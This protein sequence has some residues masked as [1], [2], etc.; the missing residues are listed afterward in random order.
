MSKLLVIRHAQASFMAEDYDNLSDFGH[1]QS[2]ALGKYLVERGV[3][4][5]HSVIG[6]LKRHHQTAHHVKEAFLKNGQSW[7]D[8]LH[9]GF[10]EHKAP[11]ITRYFLEKWNKKSNPQPITDEK[12]HKKKYFKAFEQIF[13][14]WIKDELDLSNTEFDKWLVFKNRVLHGLKEVMEQYDNGS[15]TAIFTSGGPVGVIT[16]EALGLVDEKTVEL[17][18]QVQNTSVT[19]FL[20]SKGRFTLKSFNNIAHLKPE[21]ATLV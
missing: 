8:S 16:G 14:K 20:F 17:S 11:E 12:A 4:I 19:E 3:Q 10:E 5:D 21:W 1:Q 15:T 13:R 2:A 9:A 7:E 18:W 6:P